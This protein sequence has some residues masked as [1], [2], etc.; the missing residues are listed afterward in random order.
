MALERNIGAIGVGAFLQDILPNPAPNVTPGLPPGV[1]ASPGTDWGSIVS[2]GL[3]LFTST[4]GQNPSTSGSSY[5]TNLL[6]RFPITTQTAAGVQAVIDNLRAAQASDYTANFEEQKAYGTVLLGYTTLRNKLT[7]ASNPLTSL[8]SPTATKS[9]ISWP[10]VLLLGGA[11]IYG[12]R[13]KKKTVSGTGKN[14]LVYAAIGIGGYLI[15]RNLK[16][17]QQAV[18]PPVSMPEVSSTFPTTVPVTNQATPITPQNPIPTIPPLPAIDLFSIKQ[19]NLI[20]PVGGGGTPT[21]LAV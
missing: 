4:T 6:Q 12:L 21:M 10:V 18:Q 15:V 3:N 14:L 20:P 8:F 1:T 5:V 19:Q 2:Q 16:Q 7:T 13:P 9:G 11:L 17:K